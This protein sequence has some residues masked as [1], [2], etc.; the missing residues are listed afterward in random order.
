MRRVLKTRFLFIPGLA[1]TLLLAACSATVQPTPVA[2]VEPLAT[3]VPVVVPAPPTPLPTAT[4][5][6]TP[7]VSAAPNGQ[8]GG[9]LTIAA[10]ADIPHRDVHQ[11]SQETLTTLGPGLAYSRLLRLRTGPQLDQP[12]LLLECDLCQSWQL[13]DDFS[14]QFQLRPD[15]RWQNIAPVNGRPLVADDLVYSYQRLQ[16][17]GWPSAHRFADRGIGDIEAVDSHTLRVSL[18]FLDSDALLALADGHSKI[19]APEVVAQYGDLKDSPVVGTGP[20]VWEESAPGVGT[21]LT[22]NPDYFEAGLPFLDALDIRVV[23]SSG[24]AGAVA[25]PEPLA[26]FQT[27]LVDLLAVSPTEWQQ[28]YASNLEFN[29]VLSHQAGAGILFSL[30]TQSA[31]LDNLI[32]RQSVLQALDPWAYV[33]VVWA[34][35]GSV[36]VGLPVP[37]PEWRLPSREMRNNYFASPSEARNVMVAQ[38]IPIPLD[39][40]LS[41]SDAGDTYLQL[42]QQVADNMR[43]AGFNA[44]VRALH[45]AHFNEVVL[46]PERDYQLALGPLPAINTT[47]GYLF[48]LLH[49]QG[50]GNISGHQDQ[51]LNAMIEAQAGEFDPER[52]REQ[53]LAIQRHVL[54]QAY[55]FSPV[56]SSYRWVFD[57]N[58]QGFHPNNSLS[59]YNHW[60]RVWLEQ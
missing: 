3:A 50:P 19:V 44:R 57:W 18:N 47:N 23:Q 28:L 42:A 26:A 1:L 30:N 11:S 53:L 6:P 10:L 54:E 45:P 36:G 33:D 37:G 20:W 27:N 46:G 14:Y 12:S 55:L 59:E 13:N 38:G 5:V 16:T 52:R 25:G 34:G 32:V 9:S 7:V 39:L 41:V 4:P 40:E 15:V 60:S 58:L 21:R 56:S 22:A 48:A 29:T 35:Q 8:R 49:S 24:G 43:V 2:E 31:P 17:P 51:T